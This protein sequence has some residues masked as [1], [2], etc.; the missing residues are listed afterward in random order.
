M[1]QLNPSDCGMNFTETQIESRVVMVILLSLFPA[2]IAKCACHLIKFIVACGYRA[3]VAADRHVLGREETECRNVAYGS[4]LSAFIQRTVRL[5]GIFNDIQPFFIGNLFYCIHVA[6]MTVDVHGYDCL[7][8]RRY[9]LSDIVGIYCHVVFGDIG[10]NRSSA[11]EEYRIGRGNECMRRD[12]YLIALFDVQTFKRQYQRVCAR[13]Y[14]YG[15]FYLAEFCKFLFKAAVL[16]TLDVVSALKNRCRRTLY[17]VIA[18]HLCHVYLFNC[19]FHF[20]LPH[21]RSFKFFHYTV[22]FGLI[23]D[24]A[25][26]VADRNSILGYIVDHNRAEADYGT[27]AYLHFGS[28]GYVSPNLC[29]FTYDNTFGTVAEV[30][31][32][33][34]EGV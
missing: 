24:D 15:M 23:F 9:L 25:G 21:I 11:A 2:L 18:E 5:T 26:G 19:V 30:R 20:L 33:R 14:G 16:L 22:Q 7:C 4:D 31:A 6:G 1:L 8:F 3:A 17:F 10:K 13:I 29:T 28:Y 34:V 32:R 27:P 12:N